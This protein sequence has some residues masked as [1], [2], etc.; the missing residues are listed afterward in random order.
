MKKFYMFVNAK[1]PYYREGLNTGPIPFDPTDLGG[2]VVAQEDILAFVQ[3]GDDVLYE[4]RPLGEVH[5]SLWGPKRWNTHV[6]WLTRIGESSDPAVIKRLLD[7][8]ADVDASHFGRKGEALRCAAM[9]GWLE[10]AKMLIKAGADVNAAMGSA[11]KEAVLKNDIEI[12]KLLIEAGAD[13]HVDDNWVLKSAAVK[14]YYEITELLLDQGADIHAGNDVALGSASSYGHPEVMA[15]LLKNG[16][17]PKAALAMIAKA[18]K[19]AKTKFLS[20]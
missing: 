15:L 12:V 13:V 11:L 19:A 5:E 4:A 18:S 2:M 3:A 8:G 1:N 16:A 20:S 14:G 9:S 17:D 10:I 7:E 6:V